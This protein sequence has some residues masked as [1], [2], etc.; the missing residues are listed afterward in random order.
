MKEAQYKIES[1]TRFSWG[2]V[3]YI[4]GKRHQIWA[5]NI[6]SLKRK[7]LAKDLPWDDAKVPK[8]RPTPI[9]ITHLGSIRSEGSPAQFRLPWCKSNYKRY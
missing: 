2:Y 1:Y 4:N 5:E 6:E 7:V 9:R 8:V 3:C